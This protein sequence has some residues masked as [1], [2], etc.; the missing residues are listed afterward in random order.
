MDRL[1][2]S[3]MRALNAA[4]L[5]KLGWRMVMEPGKAISCKEPHTTKKG[6]GNG[7]DLSSTRVGKV[8]HRGLSESTLLVILEVIVGGC[9]DPALRRTA[10]PVQH[11]HRLLQGSSSVPAT[12][13]SASP[14]SITAEPH[15][16]N[17]VTECLSFHSQ[18]T[19]NP[20]SALFCFS[21]LVTLVWF[22]RLFHNPLV[23]AIALLDFCFVLFQ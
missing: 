6:V 23:V 19:Q 14:H 3:S 1:G 8:H 11:H 12:G 2:V 7:G 22:G 13:H 4:S 9:R 5:M 20:C 18:I 10:W 15:R 21:G 16:S 17:S